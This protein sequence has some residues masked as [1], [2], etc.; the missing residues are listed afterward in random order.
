[1]MVDLE[2][3]SDDSDVHILV[4]FTGI[5]LLQTMSVQRE[6]LRKGIE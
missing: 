3:T 1:M 4:Q 6:I 2:S 5:S